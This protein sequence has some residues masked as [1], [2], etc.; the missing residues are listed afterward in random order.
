MAG[1]T[2]AD[3]PAGPTAARIIGGAQRLLTRL[4][5]KPGAI[6]G[7]LNDATRKALKRFETDSGFVPKGRVSGEVIAELARQAHARIEVSD[8]ALAH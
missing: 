8:E 6:D 4:G 3:E 7:Q 1:N 2:A 5:Y